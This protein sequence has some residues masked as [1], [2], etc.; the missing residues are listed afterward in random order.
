[1]TVSTK[2]RA[3][4]TWA[5]GTHGPTPYAAAAGAVPSGDL[6]PLTA[7]A[8][9]DEP[10]ADIHVRC[11]PRP[12]ESH[13]AFARRG[14]ADLADAFEQVHRE[15]RPHVVHAVGWL[16][17]L[18]WQQ[19]LGGDDEGR[20][21]V[22]EDPAQ[23]EGR[24]AMPTATDRLLPGLLR[25]ADHVVA[26]HSLQADEYVSW[27][28][29]RRQISVIAPHPAPPPTAQTDASAAVAPLGVVGRDPRARA[30]VAALLRRRLDVEAVHYDVLG[31]DGRDGAQVVACL[32]DVW[33]DGRAV[34]ST[35]SR[36]AAVVAADVGMHR[37]LVVDGVSG[38]VVDSPAAMSRA[39]EHLLT[40][41]WARES[42]GVAAQDRV[43]SRF[44]PVRLG[45]D[46]GRAW[47]ALLP[48]RADGPESEDDG[49]D[50]ELDVVTLTA[51]GP[52]GDGSPAAG[53][54][55]A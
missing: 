24:R 48:P 11:A 1:M 31:A 38:D 54:G 35:L 3:L 9:P 50:E 45:V 6:E 39:C 20:L 4:L 16:A 27:G 22:S 26:Q 51:T 33:G 32:D 53:R 37:D 49:G 36:G 41:R 23:A 34:L 28:V 8:A 42:R 15:H 30:A 13:L 52:A 10:R 40:D 43:A 5:T 14:F 17:A 25:A 47:A 19:V 18:A 44:Q 55:A 2:H 29:P 7:V 21:V 46:L 12:D